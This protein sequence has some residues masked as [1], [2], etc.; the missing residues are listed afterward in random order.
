VKGARTKLLEAR[1]RFLSV[2]HLWAARAIRE[3][4]IGALP[5]VGKVADV[6]FQSFLA[7]AESLREWGQTWRAPR[8]KSTPPLPSD[9]WRAPESWTP[10]GA[11][12]GWPEEVMLPKLTL[13]EN[14]LVELRPAGRPP[15]AGLKPYP[16]FPHKYLAAGALLKAVCWPAAGGCRHEDKKDRSMRAGKGD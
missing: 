7:E 6:D 8:A 16:F 3:A 4:K 15:Q 13:P 12:P 10:P 1:D 9:A 2:A 5:E 11:P 14:L